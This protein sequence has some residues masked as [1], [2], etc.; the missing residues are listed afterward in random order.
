MTEDLKKWH[1]PCGIY[2]KRCPGVESYGCN[3]CREQKGQILKFPICKTYE[4]VISKEYDFCFEC[5]HFPCEMVQPFVNFEIFLPHNS[6][7]YNLIMINKLGLEEWN[8]ICEDKTKL[9]YQGRKVKNGGDPLTL[10]EKD[11]NMYKKKT[12]EK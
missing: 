11:P 2:C 12:T 9:Y 7:V 5:N 3:G 1:A 4:C 6:K 10:E 8:T